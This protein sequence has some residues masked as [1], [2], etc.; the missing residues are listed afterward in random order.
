M[1]N[2]TCDVGKLGIHYLRY[3]FSGRRPVRN[4]FQSIQ[5]EGGLAAVRS[6]LSV[7]AVALNFYGVLRIEFQ[8]FARPRKRGTNRASYDSSCLAPRLANL[9]NRLGFY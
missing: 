2:G 4:A 6:L 3:F 9:F 5:V 1:D 8:P 7:A